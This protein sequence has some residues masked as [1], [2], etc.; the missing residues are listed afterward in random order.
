MFPDVKLNPALLAFLDAVA[1]RFPSGECMDRFWHF[2][3]V[4]N[5]STND[6]FGNKLFRCA[7]DNLVVCHLFISF[8]V[9][10]L[11]HGSIILLRNSNVK[12]KFAIAQSFFAIVILARIWYNECEVIT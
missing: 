2:Y 8:L 11:F 1:E 12:D 9:L 5:N 3:A 10:A 6:A 7:V 4:N